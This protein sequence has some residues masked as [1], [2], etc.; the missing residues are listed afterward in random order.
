MCGLAGVFDLSGAARPVDAPIL[1]RMT[2]ALA[3]RGPDD[4]TYF[5]APGVGF[6]HR[7]LAIID[8]AGGAQPF[9]TASSNGVLAFNGEIYNYRSLADDLRARGVHLRTRSDTETLA[10]GLDRDGADYVRGLRG[11]FAFAF[12]NAERRE[13]TLGRD[14][15]GEK[16]LYYAVTD[17][18]WLVL[19]SEI[20]AIA[21]SGL[22]DLSLDPHAVYDYLHLGY[23]PD[24]KSIYKDI[25]K[26]PPGTVLTAAMGGG[27]GFDRYWRPTL[28]TSF[29]GSIDDAG[30]AL[31]ALVDD[32]VKLQMISDAPVGAFLS[33]GLD[34]ATI[35]AAMSDRAT[36]VKTCTIGF[37]DDAFDESPFAAQVADLFDT[38]H[39]AE[40]ID[41]GVADLID[42]VARAFGE[43]FADSSALPT[44]RVCALARQRVTVALSGDGGDELFAGYRRYPFFVKEE[45]VRR[46]MPLAV[47]RATFGAAGALY[48]KL[49]WAPRPL[50][51]KTTLQSLGDNAA[52]AYLRAI[53]MSLPDRVNRMISCDFKR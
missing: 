11:M 10:E 21:A 1:K 44:Y 33:G 4:E 31:A 13:L 51:L 32:A 37:N 15:L 42:P 39:T 45:S 12:W 22:V 38:D 53:C 28:K 30:D 7:R 40:R 19:A 27:I 9:K 46:T 36:R 48:P 50:R 20:G 41:L 2:Q 25:C 26:L 47:R 8:I 18:N 52:N 35:V 43:P 6:G 16:P 17:D 23:A 24:P 34:S 29:A 14:R 5:T 49:D 3:H